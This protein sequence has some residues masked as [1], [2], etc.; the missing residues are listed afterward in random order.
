MGITYSRKEANMADYAF[1]KDKSG[2][3]HGLWLHNPADA[4][5]QFLLSGLLMKH[6]HSLS[7]L[8][9][10][11][12]VTPNTVDDSGGCFVMFG[13]EPA[14]PV[15]AKTA[16]SHSESKKKWWQFWK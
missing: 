3:V 12:R 1:V 6:G 15:Q 2:N 11:Y 13:A 9:S 5:D 8:E 7:L 14:T 16:S 4:Q 10:G